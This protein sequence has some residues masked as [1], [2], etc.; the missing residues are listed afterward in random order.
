[1]LLLRPQAAAVTQSNPREVT[2][3][4]NAELARAQEVKSSIP[5]H[6]RWLQ[7]TWHSVSNPD[8]EALR[9]RVD[10]RPEH[11]ERGILAALEA[12]VASGH[13]E[14]MTFDLWLGPTGH[15]RFNSAYSAEFKRDAALG[16][17]DAWSLADY[18]IEVFS[19]D[20]G[21]V[22]P[23]GHPGNERTV[24]WPMMA[25]FRFGGL[26][27]VASAARE[28]KTVRL[29]GSQFTAE[30][31][32]RSGTLAF[33]VDGEWRTA[34]SRGFIRQIVITRYPGK[35]DIAGTTERFLEW[36]A[37]PDGGWV[38]RQV[39]LLKPGHS[40]PWRRLSLQVL[41]EIAPEQLSHLI[42]TPRPGE[43][44]PIRGI[45]PGT[46]ITIDHRS[47]ERRWADER[48][49]T[50]SELLPDATVTQRP[51]LTT[52]YLGLVVLVSGLVAGV[53]WYWYRV[54]AVRTRRVFG[55]HR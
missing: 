35:A 30:I 45:L 47:G 18:G 17:E 13:P 50:H 25:R 37:A 23:T 49:V 16:S 15:W 51:L 10:G 36:T 28:V 27:R 34:A 40:K 5:V 29:E 24:F 33:R 7:E 14:V 11:P 8:I 1:M 21:T 46:V 22:R 31:E 12:E 3:W 38:C 42:A 48:G 41:A 39:E 20:P 32:N 2:T 4:L 6:A 44:D 9:K 54:R 55:V 43:A 19:S 52:R 53:M 26:E